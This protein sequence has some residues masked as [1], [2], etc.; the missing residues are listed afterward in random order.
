L[1]NLSSSGNPDDC[2]RH[3]SHKVLH[4][5]AA[6]LKFANDKIQRQNLKVRI[7]KFEIITFYD[8][9]EKPSES[10]TKGA[11]EQHAALGTAI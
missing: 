3:A 7:L 11:W 9:I 10:H 6:E 5:T 1:P 2:A 4:R 8:I